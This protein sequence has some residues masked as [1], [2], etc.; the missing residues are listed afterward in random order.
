MEWIKRKR[1]EKTKK[2]NVLIF[3][4]EKN[5]LDFRV[6]EPW[7]ISAFDGCILKDMGSLFT[8]VPILL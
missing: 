2:F 1:L 3:A 6:T 7:K 5:S 4:A 8:I